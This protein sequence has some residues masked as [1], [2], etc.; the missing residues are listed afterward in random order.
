MAKRRKNICEGLN[1]EKLNKTFFNL[2]R[3]GK[4]ETSIGRESKSNGRIRKELA[5][6]I[7]RR[8]QKGNKMPYFFPKYH[9][10]HLVWWRGS[11]SN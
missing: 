5:T 10:L 4:L 8:A 2:G 7:G 3:I 11:K 6:T 1:L 9:F